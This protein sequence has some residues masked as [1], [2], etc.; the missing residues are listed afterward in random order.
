M[1]GY[2]LTKG[3]NRN[4]LIDTQ[5]KILYFVPKDFEE[6]D[7]STML[8]SEYNFLE[9]ELVS[10]FSKESFDLDILEIAEIELIDSNSFET[11]LRYCNALNVKYL[12]IYLNGVLAENKAIVEKAERSLKNGDLSF[13]KIYFI[14]NEE[15]NSFKKVK[16]LNYFTFLT[17][18]DLKN[19]REVKLE[20]FVLGLNFIAVSLIKN[21]FFGGRHFIVPSKKKPYFKTSDTAQIRNATKD[22][23]QVCCDCEFRNI[24]NDTRRPKYQKR[25][26]WFHETECNYNPYISKWEDEEGYRT[27][28]ECGVISNEHEF[29]IDHEKI[30]K[31]NAEL[32]PEE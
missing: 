21:V 14:V 18:E 12:I 23:T 11:F 17:S 25:N 15:I 10:P 19:Q 1:L 20:N 9:N 13:R 29:S 22:K 4:L 3:F 6:V 2:Y 16:N 30:A 24:C 8:F 28:G 5:D 31:I 26:L 27:L 7:L 32:W